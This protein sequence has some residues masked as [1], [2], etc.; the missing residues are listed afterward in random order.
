MGALMCN[1]R[2]VSRSSGEQCCGHLAVLGRG[3]EREREEG[4][5]KGG[6]VKER[7]QEENK[8]Q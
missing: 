1:C 4:R 5:M 3:V 6:K 2:V 8:C 7:A